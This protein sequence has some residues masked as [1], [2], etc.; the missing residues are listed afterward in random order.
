MHVRLCL[1]N[2]RIDIFWLQLI[3]GFGWGWGRWLNGLNGLN[4]GFL[5]GF[6]CAER[7]GAERGVFDCASVFSSGV[8]RGGFDLGGVVWAVLSGAGL[9]IGSAAIACP[10]LVGCCCAGLVDASCDESHSSSASASRFFILSFNG[11]LSSL[12]RAER[13][14]A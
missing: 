7:G 2:Q 13:A 8:V 10:V 3:A 4:V 5:R 12:V 14:S 9:L 11:R 1:R 6:G